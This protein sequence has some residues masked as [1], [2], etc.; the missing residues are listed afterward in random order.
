LDVSRHIE[1]NVLPGES[2]LNIDLRVR[3]KKKENI[4]ENL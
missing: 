1:D 4:L 3:E 2:N